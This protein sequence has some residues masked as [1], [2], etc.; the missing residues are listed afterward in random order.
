VRDEGIPGFSDS[1]TKHRTESPIALLII[2][3]I[4]DMEFVEGEQLFK[5]ALPMAKR[6]PL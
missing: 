5:Q 1:M 2:D 6:L 4:N 3:V